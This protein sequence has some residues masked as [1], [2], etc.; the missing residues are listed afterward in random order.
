MPVEAVAE[1]DSWTRWAT[2]A[3]MLD[4]YDEMCENTINLVFTSPGV[5]LSKLCREIM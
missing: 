1:M 2:H 3:V 4:R 5:P